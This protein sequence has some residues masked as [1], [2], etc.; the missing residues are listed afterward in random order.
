MS[1]EESITTIKK[2]ANNF[3]EVFV[4]F[5]GG[6]YSSVLLDL[7][8]K[9]LGKAKA[10]YVDTTICLPEC[11]NF[12]NEI[13]ENWGVELTVI[14]RR[15]VDFWELV[16]RRGFP[17]RRFRWCMK[18]F[19][20]IPL[21]LFNKSFS[22]QVLHLVGTSMHESSF[23]KKIYSVRG[24]YHFNYSIGS[25]V[26][27]P[28]LNW[29]EDMIYDYIEIHNIPLNPCYEKYYHSGNC[30]YCPHVSS[31]TYYSRLAALRPDLFLKIV[32]AEKAM[33]KGGAA[34]Y[35]GRGKLLHLSRFKLEEIANNPVA[36]YPKS[37]IR[38]PNEAR[39]IS[40]LFGCQKRC[41]M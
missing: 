2:Y 24:M 15:D 21:R 23:R 10:V 39:I 9:A 12:V 5:S 16:K 33:R 3:N 26:L 25:Y 30:Y 8:L 14:K 32:D 1:I 6:R 7:V 38:N 35:L 31:I 17:H 28:L 29:T 18:E 4:D 19:K 40:S 22:G 20:S 34:V 41:L 13:C 11:N 37:S 27:H 36:N